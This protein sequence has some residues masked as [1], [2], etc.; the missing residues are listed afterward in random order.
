MKLSEDF[1][2]EFVRSASDGP[3]AM[4]LSQKNWVM[5][6]GLGLDESSDETVR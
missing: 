4:N 1:N 6:A 2:F 5:G 3:I